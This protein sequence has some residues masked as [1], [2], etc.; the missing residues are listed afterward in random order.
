M[1]P[2]S[3]KEG[4]EKAIGNCKSMEKIKK[5]TFNNKPDKSAVLKMKKGKKKEEECIKTQVR[6]GEISMVKDYKYLGEW[7]TQSGSREMSFKKRNH[8]VEFVLREIKRY[9]DESKVG[10]LALEVRKKI[11]ETVVVPTLFAN[12]ETWSTV[13][14]NERKELESMQYRILRGMFELP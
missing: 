3:R 11:Y 6:K 13:N 5:F 2:T 9:G 8:K 12:V 10:M 1:F 7:Y 14:E 4:I